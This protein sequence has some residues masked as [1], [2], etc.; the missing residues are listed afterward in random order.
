MD[1]AQFVPA[2]A[3]ALG[4]AA[5]GIVVVTYRKR[6]IGNQLARVAYLQE[7]ARVKSDTESERIRRSI[8]ES[9]NTPE[10]MGL[11]YVYFRTVP[12][13][14]RDVVYFL[15]NHPVKDRI[16]DDHVWLFEKLNN[17]LEPKDCDDIFDA[18]QESLDKDGF[19][20]LIGLLLEKRKIQV[21]SS[22]A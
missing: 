8:V 6:T 19:E 3:C 2:I 11:L 12:A 21:E 17:K 4:M 18:Y 13:V 1:M 9:K 5:I 10:R 15:V 22:S 16:E 7:I 14:D 20:R